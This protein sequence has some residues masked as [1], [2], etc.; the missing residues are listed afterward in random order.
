MAT[1]SYK[2]KIEEANEIYQ[3][4]LQQ[5]AQQVYDAMV[6]QGNANVAGLEAAQTQ[7]TADLNAAQQRYRA[8]MDAGLKGFSDIILNEQ[9]RVRQEQQ[10]AADRVKADNQA[11]K[12][13]GLGEL[14]A[15]VANLIGVGGHNA[16]SQQ[17]KQYS[18]DW[19]RKADQDMREHR[20]RM[21]N[22]NARLNALKQQ[23]LQLQMGDAQQALAQAQQ[24]AD[25]A[26]NNRIAMMQ[27]RNAAAL[28]P[29][30]YRA[31][32]EAKI[33]EAA[34][35]GAQRAASVGMQEANLGLQQRQ[36]NMR[37]QQFQREMANDDLAKQMQGFVPDGK[38]GY[39]YNPDKAA[40]NMGFKDAAAM[41]K[42]VGGGNNNKNGKP[43]HVKIDGQDVVL[44]LEDRAYDQAIQS[45]T[46]Y[47]Q[48]DIMD[49]AGYKGN[50]RDFV[51]AVEGDRKGKKY[52][53]DLRGV[54]AALQGSG[55]NAAD[56]DVI[57]RY[58]KDNSNK[59]NN[60]NKHLAITAGQGYNTGSVR[61]AAPARQQSGNSIDDEIFGSSETSSMWNQP[62]RENW[63]LS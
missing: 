6:Q 2:K 7:Q 15:S 60:F 61:A 24:N 5:G 42:A 23:Q 40:T 39:T 12:W 36:M 26:Y 38:G 45:G 27:A 19:M 3:E 41:A 34:V 13:T 48:Q 54:I 25:R 16:V 28:D 56:L 20:Y 21:D 31:E 47:L 57:S 44:N 46:S 58:V 30:R 37:E 22:V 53:S 50:W 1:D 17:Y 55:D 51:G 29:V 14:A 59:L 8:G 43:Y 52:D 62:K 10:A 9:D 33:G 35:E 32:A 4:G 11:A 63:V 18:Q 49:A